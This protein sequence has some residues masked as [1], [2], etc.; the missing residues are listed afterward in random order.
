MPSYGLFPIVSALK[1][2]GHGVRAYCEASGS[3]VDWRVVD[4]AD[5]VCLSLLSFSSHKGY[6]YADRIRRHN[7][8]ATIIIGGAHAS[9]LPEDCLRHCDYVVRNEGE[10][11]LLALLN[12]LENHGDTARIGGVSFIDENGLAV[13]NSSAGFIDKL[14]CVADP[15]DILGY[16]ARTPCSYFLDMIKRGVFRFNCAIVQSSRGC[17]FAC[18]FCFVKYES[19][20]EYRVKDPK[21]VLEEI[22]QS[23]SL[24]KTRYV[25]FA[26]N[27]L[28]GN[29][30]QALE[31]LRLIEQRFH[32]DIDLCFFTRIFT[33]MDDEMMRAIERAGRACL[34]VGVEFLEESALDVFN[35][36]QTLRDIDECLDRFGRYNIKLQPLFVF[37]TDTDD[38]NCVEKALAL[39]LKHKCYNWGFSSLFDFPSREKVLGQPQVISDHRFIHSDWRF[40]TGNFVIHYPARMRPSELQREMASAQRRFYRLNKEAFHHYYPLH[41]TY[42]PYIEFLEKAEEGL[43]NNDGTLREDLLPSKHMETPRIDVSFSRTVLWKEIASYY[44]VNMTR[45]QSWKYLLSLRNKAT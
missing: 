29:R 6:E 20:Q 18:K 19:G 30:S 1:G 33:A 9:V 35:K 43:Y 13:H 5:A 7:P 41:A 32:G 26:D 8:D 36:K 14:T 34:I 2:A 12:A 42:V 44:F 11:A 28:V 25:F 4:S 24:L 15:R 31:L 10:A 23:V 38:I 3:K 37:G 39:V 21:L 27:D 45:I 40:Y 22:E 17:P 16:A